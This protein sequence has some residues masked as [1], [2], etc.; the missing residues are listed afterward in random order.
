VK[1]TGKARFI[2]C[3]IAV[4]L[5]LAAPGQARANVEPLLAEINRKPPEQRLKALIEGAKKE[6]VFHYHGATNVNDMQ[7]L[8]TGF[9]RQYPFIDV[10][11]TRLGGPSV[12][13]KIITEYRGGI[14][15]VDAISMRGTLIPELASKNLLA[16][17]KSPE[18]LFLRQG[19]ADAQGYAAGYYATGY[20]LLYNSTRVKPAEVPKSYDDLLNPRWKGRLVMDR[21]EYDWLAGMIVLMGE[22]KAISFLRRL[23]EEQSLK[24]QRGHSLITQLVAAG[25]YDLLVDGY[26]QQALQF[27]TKAAPI[28]FVFMNP[29]V[30]KP[31]TVIAI[32]LNAPHPHGAAL[33]VDY[34]LAKET[35]E[36]MAQ[37]LFYWTSRR[38]VKWTPEPGTDLRVL[39]SFEWGPKYNNLRE[40]FRKTIGQ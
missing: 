12:V 22:S 8:L 17:Y 32:G 26:A 20:T 25:E 9:R 24:F 38:D 7:D 2:V 29:T 39:S 16:K 37:R 28:D 30:V 1:P 15:N 10:R 18:T 36:M 40:L 19:F 4:G 33:L 11:Y 23:V 31:P 6:G 13:N 27:K 21:E 3:L 35:Q 34:H 5:R 14:F